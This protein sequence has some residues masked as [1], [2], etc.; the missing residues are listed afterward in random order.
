MAYELYPNEYGAVLRGRLEAT[1]G[2]DPTVGD[3]DT[4]RCPPEATFNSFK[5]AMLPRRTQAAFISGI[6][7]SAGAAMGEYSIEVPLD[8]Y[9]VSSPT[10]TGT[11]ADVPQADLWL[12]A[13]GFVASATSNADYSGLKPDGVTLSAGNN[14]EILT[15]TYKPRH[16]QAI[17]SAR[18]EYTEIND[19]Q[20]EGR[21]HILSGARHG[22]TLRLAD[23]ERWVLACQGKSLATPIAKDSSPTVNSAFADSTDVVGLGTNYSLTKVVATADTYGKSSETADASTLT[24][25]VYGM[26]ITSNLEVVEVTNQSA[27]YGVGQIRYRAGTP[28]ATCNLDQVTFSDDFDIE[29]FRDERRILRWTCA[30]PAPGASPTDFIVVSFE[31]YITDISYVYGDNG[32][33]QAQLS[34]DFGYP[35][36]SSDGGGRTPATVLTIKYVSIVAA[37]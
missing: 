21:T 31:A 32:Y 2:T 37:P 22:W 29:T 33:R 17:S 3:S 18:L 9:T 11:I 35:D 4:Y 15:Y 30:N 1:Y 6:K 7:P 10:L 36:A 14:D 16:G 28:T 5:R 19:A 20:D 23:G 26:E 25:Y 34:L 13:G 12:R 27:S 8:Y 24:G